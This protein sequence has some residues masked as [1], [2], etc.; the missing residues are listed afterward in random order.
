[1]TSSRTLVAVAAT[2][3]LLSACSG[4]SGGAPSGDGGGSPRTESEAPAV[5]LGVSVE[6]LLSEPV[7]LSLQISTETLDAGPQ[8]MTADGVLDS[9]LASLDIDASQAPNAAG[10]YGHYDEIAAVFEGTDAYYAVVPGEKWLYVT[11]ERGS[12]FVGADIARLRDL[13]LANP[14]LIGQLLQEAPE[15]TG[16]G[17][18]SE[19]TLDFEVTPAGSELAGQLEELFGVHKIPFSV[20]T[21]ADGVIT[22]IDVTFVYEVVK[23]TE[24]LN[25]V[26]VTIEITDP[27]D[28]DIELPEDASIQEL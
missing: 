13:S 15:A 24:A 5:D 2:G 14:A 22:K 28:P 16:S 6:T 21:D 8:E 26:E 27:A 23:D 3:L 1:M 12:S 20:T 10:F 9:E 4:G 19:A 17:V 7:E 18:T 25:T 11:L